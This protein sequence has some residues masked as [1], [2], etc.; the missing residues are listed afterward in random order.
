[1][2]RTRAL[3][4]RRDGA[5][6][7]EALA[8]LVSAAAGTENVLPRIRGCVEADVTLGEIAG[9]LRDVWGEHRP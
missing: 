7:G 8:A 1:V 5:R 6:A 9:A 2:A 3:R 4:E